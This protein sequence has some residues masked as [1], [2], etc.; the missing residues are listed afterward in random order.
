MNKYDCLLGMGDN[1]TATGW[2][3]KTKFREKYE[4]YQDWMDKQTV[5]RKLA[6]LILDS[7]SVFYNQWLKGI[8]NVV[9]DS[10]S[11]DVHL[12][13]NTLHVSFLQKNDC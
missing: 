13:S 5:A 11:R 4:G 9:I 10:L 2:C 12:F 1:K 3:H 7:D 6:N 8:C